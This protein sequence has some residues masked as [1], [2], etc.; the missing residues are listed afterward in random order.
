MKD[1]FSG[2]KWAI[3]KGAEGP[4][5][6]IWGLSGGKAGKE[7]GHVTKSVFLGRAKLRKSY[8]D[9]SNHQTHKE[10]GRIVPM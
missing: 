6:R 10:R 8:F 3:E 1:Q 2:S 4:R 5:N 7:M 9:N